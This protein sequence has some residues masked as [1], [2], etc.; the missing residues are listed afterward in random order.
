SLDVSPDGRW[1]A[2]DLL[3]QVYRMPIEG[4]EAACLTCDAGVSVNYHPRFSPD[5]TRIAFVSD[6]GG[7]TNPW[8]MAADGSDP[9]PVFLDLDVRVNEPRWMPDG[10]HL[11]LRRSGGGSGLWLVPV[12]EGGDPARPLLPTQGGAQGPSIS[13]DGRYLYYHVSTGAPGMVEGRWQIRR[14]EIAT[15]QV[16]EITTGVDQ[17]Q[18]RGSSGGALAPAIAPDGRRLAF[19]RRIPD[20]TV[21]FRGH[22]IGPRTALFLRDL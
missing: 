16:S 1:I 21:S 5:G 15:G 4:G 18:Y 14:L 19:A 8:V 20:G 12:D 10:R 9:R 17:A 3:G 6:R 22:R 7:Q 2:F 11:V 13:A